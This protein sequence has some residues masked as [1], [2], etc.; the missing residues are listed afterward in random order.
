[1]AFSL[2]EI[3]ATWLYLLTPQKYKKNES[4]THFKQKFAKTA[5]WAHMKLKLDMCGV[6]RKLVE[7]VIAKT[8]KETKIF[9]FK[10][11]LELK[12]KRILCQL[13]GIWL[14]LPCSN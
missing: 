8:A 12:T 11:F 6:A 13:L 5:N 2:W 1:M 7:N 9:G 14:Y 10:E 4:T 3:L